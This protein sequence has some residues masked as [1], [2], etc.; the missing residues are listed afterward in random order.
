MYGLH[1]LQMRAFLEA[2]VKPD[3]DAHRKVLMLL[4][5]ELVGGHLEAVTARVSVSCKAFCIISAE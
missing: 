2:A 1:S 5:F 3:E 4:A